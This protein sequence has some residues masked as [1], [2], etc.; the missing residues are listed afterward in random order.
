MSDRVLERLDP[1]V[2]LDFDRRVKPIA[3]D[4]DAREWAINEQVL[5]LHA[6]LT[7]VGYICPAAIIRS[8]KERRPSGYSPATGPTFSG[9]APDE[10]FRALLRNA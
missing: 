8:H 6:G 1:K 9:S 7:L 10:S 5:R 4:A 2:F 3:R